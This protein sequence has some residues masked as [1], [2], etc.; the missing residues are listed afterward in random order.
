MIWPSQPPRSL[1]WN[2]PIEF[3]GPAEEIYAETGVYPQRVAELAGRGRLRGA[4]ICELVVFPLRYI[5]VEQ[6]LILH[7]EV[8]LEIEYRWQ[9]SLSGSG[10]E[11]FDPEVVGSIISNT[12]ELREMKPQRIHDGSP[13][14]LGGEPV[15]YLI[16]TADSL[17]D[18]FEPLRLWKT[19]KG[20]AAR[21]VSVETITYSYSGRD[22]A[23]RIRNCIKDFHSDSETDWVLLGGDTQII[24]DRKAYVPLSDKPY[25]PCDL[26]YSDL[27]GNWNDD[28]DLYWGEVSADDIDMYADVY[29][30]RAPVASGREVTTFVDKVLA[31]ETYSGAPLGHELDMLFMGE[32]L[33][34]D[35]ENPFDP[36]YTDAGVAKDLID[37]AYV[38]ARFA[39][40]KLY[41][42]T[43]TLNYDRTMAALNQG[44]NIINV[45]CHG[46]YTSFS[47]GFDRVRETDI[48]SLVNGQRY[49]LMYSASCLCGG[50][51]QNDCLG[52]TWVLTPDGG[53]FFIGNSRYGFNSPSF[54]GEGPSDYYDQSFF[55]SIF[56]TG[57]T[58]LGKAH[59]DAKHEFVAESRTDKYMRYV[60]YGLNLFGDPEMRLWTNSPAELEV[61]FVSEIGLD[62]QIFSVSVTSGGS[63]VSGATVCLCKIDE[64][65]SVA[66]T[67][68]AG[69]VDVFIDPITEGPLFVTVTKANF[70]P[71]SS[72]ADVTDGVTSVMPPLDGTAQGASVGPNPFTHTLNISFD[73][74]TQ[75]V[76][77]I[78]LYDT[79]GRWVADVPVA[80]TGDNTWY[81]SWDGR[82]GSGRKLAPGIYVVRFSTDTAT[83]SH[84]VILLN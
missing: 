2:D 19:K 35:P 72:Q 40:E 31:Y 56:V 70:V 36:D 48:T 52:E 75:A 42:S 49:G 44:K 60:M 12:A 34:G 82:D 16:I 8:A 41:E 59:A 23:E 37:G 9:T 18:Y 25:L 7:T 46:Q 38:P 45:L 30:G 11:V 47:I 76:V 50:F 1:S 58:N 67:D 32:I 17:R 65:Y 66:E 68:G 29:V 24:P 84:K 81:G 77:K 79:N 83:S 78:G 64:V 73:A 14:P 39:I 55:E 10:A 43:H 20:L 53:G 74:G 26:Y 3:V 6:R 61:T 54:P 15:V 4:T 21:T 5:P 71:F 80:K 28:G 62:P 69:E 57:F 63:P 33:W 22:L 13:I 51:D 27:D